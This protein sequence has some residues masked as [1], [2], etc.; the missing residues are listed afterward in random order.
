MVKNH[1]NVLFN[2]VFEILSLL[3]NIVTTQVNFIRTKIGGKCQNPNETIWVIFKHCATQDIVSVF[4][5]WSP[6]LVAA[7]VE[8]LAI[9]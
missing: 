9:H 6:S 3:S 1:R 8:L 7:S 2:R 5:C 4:E